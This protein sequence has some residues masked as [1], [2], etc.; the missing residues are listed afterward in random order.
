MAGSRRTTEFSYLEPASAAVAVE[1]HRMDSDSSVPV[2]V[3]DSIHYC[4][5]LEGEE[6]FAIAAGADT[7]VAVV[8]RSVAYVQEKVNLNERLIEEEPNEEGEV[9]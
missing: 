7:E 2:P 9:G 3:P 4:C 8:V 5:N 1:L 6:V